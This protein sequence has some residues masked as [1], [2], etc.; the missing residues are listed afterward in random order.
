V[1]NQS[2]QRGDR[3]PLGEAHTYHSTRDEGVEEA[4][5][6]I[7]DKGDRATSPHGDRIIRESS[8][9]LDEDGGGSTCLEVGPG[10]RKDKRNYPEPQTEVEYIPIMENIKEA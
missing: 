2:I 5:G 3:T 6:N 10:R 4:R 7:A 8:T 9:D 1:D